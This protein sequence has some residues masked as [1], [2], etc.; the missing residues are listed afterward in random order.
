M[1][2]ICMILFLLFLLYSDHSNS[3][4]KAKVKGEDKKGMTNRKQNNY[5]RSCIKLIN[6]YFFFKW[7]VK[8]HIENNASDQAAK[9]LVLLSCLGAMLSKAP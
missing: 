7:L 2:E 6:I 5:L 4:V 9:S 3:S 8:M 1:Q